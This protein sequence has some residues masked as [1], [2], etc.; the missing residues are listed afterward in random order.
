MGSA[1][2]GVGGGEGGE[3]AKQRVRGS[4]LL[5]RWRGAARDYTVINCSAELKGT[6]LGYFSAPQI[7][8]WSQQAF[9]HDKFRNSQQQCTVQL[10]K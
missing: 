9:I 7:R 3:G 4:A 5:F 1:V 2:R 10:V 8:S 6:V